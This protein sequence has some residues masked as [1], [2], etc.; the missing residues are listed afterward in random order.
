MRRRSPTL[1]VEWRI[2]VRETLTALLAHGG[3][4]TGF[5]R[6]GWYIVE[7]HTEGEG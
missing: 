6:A 3:R 4:I 5:D 7:Q 1:A 2:A